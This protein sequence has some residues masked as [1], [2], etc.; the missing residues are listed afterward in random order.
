MTGEHQMCKYQA[1][2]VNSIGNEKPHTCIN[3]E[4][5]RKYLLEKYNPS[6]A[7]GHCLLPKRKDQSK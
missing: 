5:K 4:L 3:M 2:M 1:T 6:K 7:S